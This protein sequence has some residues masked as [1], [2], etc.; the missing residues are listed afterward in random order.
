MITL[1]SNSPQFDPGDHGTTFGGNPVAAAAGIAAI[2]FITK[3]RLMTAAKSFEKRLKIKLTAIRGVTEVRGRGLLLGIGLNGD[4][5]KALAAKLAE[6]G[7]LVN[8]PNADTIRIAPALIV[9]KAQIDKFINIFAQCMSE[10][11]HG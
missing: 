6:R 11:E 9:S 10:V 1:G 3:N 4:Y 2:D 5:A 8:A 7:V